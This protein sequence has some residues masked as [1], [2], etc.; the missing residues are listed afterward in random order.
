MTETK[1]LW[2]TEEA[3]RYFK[4]FISNVEDTDISSL[5]GERDNTSSS[6]GGLIK[7]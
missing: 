7:P 6:I 2:L 4:D 1:C 5:D 3:E